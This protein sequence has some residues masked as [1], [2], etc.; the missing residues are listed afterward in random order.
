MNSVRRA[1]ALA[2]IALTPQEQ[3]TLER[4]LAPVLEA[5]QVL[6]RLEP[7]APDEQWDERLDEDRA[8]RENQPLRED[9][10]LEGLRRGE[11]L[12]QAPAADEGG[13]FVVPRF[14]ER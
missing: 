1:A 12:A 3:A 10:S 14:V 7:L 9:L 5:I 2:R 11:V 8:L 6:E 4:Q 13:C